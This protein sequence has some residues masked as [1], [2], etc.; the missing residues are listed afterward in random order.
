MKMSQ[1]EERLSI[2]NEN[3]EGL[4]VSVFQRKAMKAK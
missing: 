1:P 3:N 4:V 2:P